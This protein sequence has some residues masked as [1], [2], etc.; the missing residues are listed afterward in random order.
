MQKEFQVVKLMMNR[1]GHSTW[2]EADNDEK[3]ILLVCL[4]TLI[5]ASLLLTFA[6]GVVMC[7]C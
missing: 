7:V 5:V 3:L 4:P 2:F 6:A 1:S